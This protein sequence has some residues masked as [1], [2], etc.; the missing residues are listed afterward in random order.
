M[1]RKNLAC[2][3]SNA[4]RLPARQE[5]IAIR[6]GDQP[7]GLCTWSRY[8]KSKVRKWYFDIGEGWRRTT[9]LN[10]AKFTRIFEEIDGL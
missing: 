5:L 10:S 8:Q 2:P 7:M 1:G 6:Y 4:I 9:K 3:L